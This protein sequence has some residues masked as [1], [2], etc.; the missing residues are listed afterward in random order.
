MLLWKLFYR[1]T[2]WKSPVRAFRNSRGLTWRCELSLYVRIQIYI[3]I[4]VPP[5]PPTFFFYLCL[6]SIYT[7]DTLYFIL[8]R[9]M[10]LL[11]FQHYLFKFFFYTT[12]V[13]DVYIV[14]HFC[15]WTHK[16]IQRTLSIYLYT[17]L[18]HAELYNEVNSENVYN[19][20]LFWIH[21]A[22]NFYHCVIR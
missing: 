11:V 19:L 6:F 3:C 5:P 2:C 9:Y 20:I 8:S 7:R 16:Y 17:L 13:S 4:F 10:S 1:E 12:F 18:V 14:A 22:C 21:I 15:T